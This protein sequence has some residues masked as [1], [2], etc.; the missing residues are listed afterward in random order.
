MLHGFGANHTTA[1]SQMT[2]AQAVAVHAEGGPI[3]PVAM[4]TVDGGGGYWNPHPDD[5]PMAMVV[6]E[7]IP[8]C[9]DVGLGRGTRRIGA[10]GISMGGYGALLLGEQR[11]DLIGAV[12]AISPAIWT[13]Y[14]EA[15]GA[16]AQAFS[17]SASFATG[18]VIAHA[19]A[20]AGTPTRVVSGDDDPFH[21]GVEAFAGSVPAG[22]DVQFSPGC[23]TD[24]FFSSQQPRSMAF[25][26][27]HLTP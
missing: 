10:M 12:S 23:H 18:N 8:L 3:P 14:S 4:V 11:P 9:H 16:N 19:G 15:R 20:L 24:P 7:L 27:G 1:L 22:V 25:L 26:A 13:T 17:S 5:D 6:D 2:P 21:P